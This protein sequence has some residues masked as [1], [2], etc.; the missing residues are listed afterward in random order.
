ML[1]RTLLML[2]LLATAAHAHSYEAG[3]IKIGHAWSLP[4]PMGI[5]GQVFMPL[6]NTGKM[7]DA[8]VAARSEVCTF[9][10]FRAH[11]KYDI[12]AM[13]EFYLE[14]NKPFPM[15]PTDR[16]LR[17]VGLNKPLVLGERFMLVLDFLNAGETEV[18]VYVENSPGD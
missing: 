17:L 15:R 14:P 16:H 11:N 5:D 10:E 6:L 12:L 3:G 9:I 7:P 13:K 2:P 4:A 8:L 1:R 18:E